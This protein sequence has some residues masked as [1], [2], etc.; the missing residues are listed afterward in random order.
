MKKFLLFGALFFS[1]SSFSQ[2][3]SGLKLELFFDV[4]R[5]VLTKQHLMLLDSAFIG[6]NLVITTI[7]GFAD[8]TGDASYNMDLSQKR[9]GAVSQY[10]TSN[11]SDSI[12]IVYYGE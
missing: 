11:H 6:K 9:A 3:N 8:S 1:I 4:N 5:S 10:F 12:S 2:Q 7:R